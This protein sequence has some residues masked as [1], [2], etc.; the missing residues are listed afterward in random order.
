MCIRDRNNAY[1]SAWGIYWS[2]NGS[3]NNHY[4]NSDSNPNQIIFVGN[5]TGRACIDLDNG[6]IRT[7]DWFYI[8]GSDDGIYWEQHGGGWNMTDSTWMRLYGDKRIYMSNGGL[9]I[10][11]CLSLI[12]I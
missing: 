1:A 12:H 8:D 7:K 5:G 4:F 11:A 3:G 9:R 6:A 10:D 2:T